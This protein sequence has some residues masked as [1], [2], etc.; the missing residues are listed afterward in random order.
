MHNR[1]YKS[2]YY[3]QPGYKLIQFFCVTNFINS[4]KHRLRRTLQ[5]LYINEQ[6]SILYSAQ[7]LDSNQFLS[8]AG[9]TNNFF[10]VV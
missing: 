6:I 4:I 2:L 8:V 9:E 3:K 10:A 1:S 7:D 5:R